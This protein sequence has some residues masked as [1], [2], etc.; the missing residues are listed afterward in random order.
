MP[1]GKSQ[2]KYPFPALH[3]TEIQAEIHAG[4][5]SEPPP[6]PRAKTHIRNF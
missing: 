6:E 3:P 1:P 4:I 5:I 2:K